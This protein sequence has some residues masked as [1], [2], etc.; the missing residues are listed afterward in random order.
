MIVKMD[1]IQAIGSAQF[2]PV[3]EKAKTPAFAR[4]LTRFLLLIFALMPLF[5]LFVPWQQT[6]KGRGQVIAYAPVERKQKIESQ[7][8]GVIKRWHVVEGSFVK[9]GDP[10][11]DIDDVDP[12]L[13]MRLEAQKG[14]LLSRREAAQDEVA[15]QTKA[16]AAQEKSMEAS[17]KAAQ[18]KRE[19]SA[20]M[21]TVSEKS[22]E[23]TEFS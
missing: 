21:V 15:E 2:F 3:L 16:V 17:I 14:F 13:A 22:K 6:V 18:A 23:N 7:I 20:M 9:S 8:S 4:Y 19:A 11:V 10:I 12:N 5:L 1:S